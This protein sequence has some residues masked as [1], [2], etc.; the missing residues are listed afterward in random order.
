MNQV[1]KKKVL[2]IKAG[3]LKNYPAL[4]DKL[5]GSSLPG[6]PQFVHISKSAIFA[7]LFK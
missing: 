6:F 7:N 1:Y 5:R 3:F 4:S 2:P